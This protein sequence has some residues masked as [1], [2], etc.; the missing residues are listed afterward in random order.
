MQLENK[1]KKRPPC[2]ATRKEKFYMDNVPQKIEI[3][4]ND[5]FGQVRALEI[6][7]EPW[8]IAKDVCDCLDI[9]NPSQALSRLDDDEKNTIILNEGIPG[10]PNKA[11]VNEYGLYSLI[12]SSRKPEAHEFKRWITH[13]AIPSIRKHGAYATPATI[14]NII[15]NPDFGIELLQK[16]KEEQVKRK[17]VELENEEMKPKAIFADAVSVSDDAILIGAL[18]KLLKQN[19]VEI[20]QKRLFLWLRENGYLVKDGRDKN[21]PTQRA[22]ELKLFK[23]KERTITN[24]DGSSRL[25]R[26]TLVTGKG[27]QYFVNK[28]LGGASYGR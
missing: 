19:G 5:T 1:Q 15:N 13:D 16:L 4:N 17:Q 11:I 24:P 18:A 8:F 10:N 6:D 12:L 22:M 21:I 20:G 26:T 9:N 27:Q 28:F 3:F 7:G 25:T 2:T 14:E 23:V